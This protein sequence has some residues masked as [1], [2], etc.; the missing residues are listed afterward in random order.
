LI[1]RWRKEYREKGAQSFP[2]NGVQSQTADAKEL[3]YFKKT[4]DGG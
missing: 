1:H 2:G 4:A 3:W